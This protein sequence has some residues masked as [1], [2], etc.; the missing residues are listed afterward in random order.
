MFTKNNF[1][2][3]V[4]YWAPLPGDTGTGAKLMAA[5]RTLKVRWEDKQEQILD[6]KGQQ[7][8]SKAMVFT[9]SDDPLEI[10]GFLY[11]GI[12]VIPEPRNVLNAFAIIQ[13]MRIPDLRN[14]MAENVAII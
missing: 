9:P 12:S 14:L 3:K 4:T 13:I 5:P 10:D 7:T 2:Q 1:Q 6:T 11:Y 8:I